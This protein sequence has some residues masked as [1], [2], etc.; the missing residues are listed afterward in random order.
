M[1]PLQKKIVITL[2]ALIALTRL[3]A[4]AR[5]L[6]DWDEALFSLGIREYDVARHHP[7]PPGYPLFIAAGKLLHLLGLDEFHALQVVVV[8]G[9]MALFPALFWLA[10]E[11]GFGFTTALCGAGIYCFLPNVWV[12][13]GT[14]FSDV[15]ALALT[16]A[17]CAL[18]LRGRSDERAYVAGAVLLGVAA[19]IRTPSLLIGA[20]PALLATWH[21]LRARSWA[22]VA[23]AMISGAL[24]AGSSYTGAALASTSVPEYR[25]AVEGQAKWVREVDSWRNPGR[26]SLANAAKTFLLSPIGNFAVLPFLA[27]CAIVSLVVAAVRRRVPPLLFLATFAPLAVAS[28]LNFDLQAASRYALAYMPIHAMG[29]ADAFRVVGRKRPVQIALSVGLVVVTIVWT[30][31]ALRL[32]RSSD[33]PPVAALQ[34]V[35]RNVRTTEQVYVHNSYRP[36]AQLLL[37]QHRVTLWQETSEIP[38]EAVNA[39]VVDWRI[40]PGA[41]NF[42]YPRSS[43]WKILRAR[44]FEVSVSRVAGLVRHGHGWYAEEGSGLDTWRWMGAESVTLLPPLGSNGRLAMRLIVPR[45][46]E[47]QPPAIDIV[48]DGRLVDRI[49]GVGGEIDRAWILPAHRGTRELRI[50]TSATIN[51]ARLGISHDTRDLGLMVRNLSWTAV[52]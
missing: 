15:P 49:E 34:W 13:G 11:A 31:P 17:A 29:A 27:F 37:P 50:R 1:T 23:L 22:A 48:V 28:W 52:R 21:R 16:F 47:A 25:A 24:I 51:P 19:G 42:V 40:R 26:G 7:H 9:A 5:T 18:L 32:M 2:S 36:H 46:L 35:A 44:N 8:A 41:H 20:V 33:A 6:F 30:W 10:R 45:E 38:T 3:L 12:Y 43:L 4:V 14:A 39:W